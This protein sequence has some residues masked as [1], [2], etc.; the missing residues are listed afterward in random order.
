MICC[1]CLPSNFSCVMIVFCLV[2]VRLV[3]FFASS[4]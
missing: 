2:V 1:N 3:D 4:G